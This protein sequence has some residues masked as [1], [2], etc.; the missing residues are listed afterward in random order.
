MRFQPTID[1]WSIPQSQVT[2]LQVGQWVSAGTAQKD[3]LNCGRFL[4]VKRSGTIVVAWNGNVN[5]QPKNV[6]KD[7]LQVLRNYAKH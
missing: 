6:R 1:I 7:Y 2:Q 5:A 4:G 3:R